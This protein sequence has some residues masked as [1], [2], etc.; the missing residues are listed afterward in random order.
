MFAF[1]GVFLSKM[2]AFFRFFFLKVT[3]IIFVGICLF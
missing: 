3:F 2:M 1:I